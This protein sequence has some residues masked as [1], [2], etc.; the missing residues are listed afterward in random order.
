MLTFN[1]SENQHYSIRNSRYLQ[2][3]PSQFRPRNLPDDINYV[4]VVEANNE[5]D[6]KFPLFNPK[7]SQ[8]RLEDPL[9]TDSSTAAKLTNDL[10]ISK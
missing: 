7:V 5:P 4:E 1:L 6:A 9:K 10:I 2:A 3:C 8:R